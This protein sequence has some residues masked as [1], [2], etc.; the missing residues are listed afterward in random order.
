MAK[1]RRI[2]RKYKAA[3]R[4]TFDDFQ[5]P[6]N[7]ALVVLGGFLVG[8][9]LAYQRFDDP[10]WYAS[11]W[12]SMFLVGMLIVSSMLTLGHTANRVLRRTMQFSIVICAILHLLLL[13]LSLESTIF[14][15]SWTEEVAQ[16]DLMQKKEVIVAQRH[17]LR[18]KRP[19]EDMD[20]DRP[21]ETKEPEPVPRE[22]DRPEPEPQKTP[23]PPQPRP[24]DKPQEA[25]PE[26][27]QQRAEQAP[28]VPRMSEQASKLSR[29]QAEMVTASQQ[30]VAVPVQPRQQPST[31]P[32]MQSSSQQTARAETS[33]TVRQTSSR[34]SLPVS[35]GSRPVMSSVPRA[36]S[37]LS[38]RLLLAPALRSPGRK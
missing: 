36:S 26:V 12:I 15:R 35:H 27:V 17:P 25:K 13:V 3:T 38:P 30:A 1:N 16:R 32:S 2:V 23:L 22:I 20:I 10:R 19:T 7:M 31:R 14:S 34:F 33:A 37:R 29:H 8:S 28:V 5:W 11:P 18:V 24:V 21:V 6:V 4:A 9:I